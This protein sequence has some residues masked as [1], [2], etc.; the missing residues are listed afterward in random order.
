MSDVLLADASDAV[1]LAFR[2][3][4]EEQ[5]RKAARDAGIEIKNFR[6][7]YHA[8]ESLKKALEGM[9]APARE[10]VRLGVAE[11]RAVF[12]ISRIGT[13]AGCYVQR[14]EI[15]RGRGARLQRDGKVVYEGRIE[16]LRREKNDAR[17]VETG[18]ECGIGLE[19]YNDIKVGDLIECFTVK[20]TARTLG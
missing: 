3:A 1:I 4:T 19:R 18:F 6:V 8:I 20:E 5:A 15:Q 10:E 9:L 11:V 12:N 13:I 7:I 17:Q 16:S 14:G 2:V